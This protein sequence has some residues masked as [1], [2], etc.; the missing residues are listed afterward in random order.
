[1]PNLKY[2]FSTTIKL[3]KGLI[4]L[5]LKIFHLNWTNFDYKFSSVK[6]QVF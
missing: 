1:M 6:Y 4:S 3:I 5:E 2:K